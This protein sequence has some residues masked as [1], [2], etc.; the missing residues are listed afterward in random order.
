[1]GS[2]MCIRDRVQWQS[3]EGGARLLVKD[4]GPG[5]DASHINHITARFY[6][7]DNENSRESSGTGLGLSIV[8]HIVQRHRGVLDIRSNPGEGTSFDIRFPAEVVTRDVQGD[9]ASSE[10]AP[11]ELA[12]SDIAPSE[13]T[14]TDLASSGSAPTD[15]D[16]VVRRLPGLG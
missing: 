14:P 5:I 4:N 16:R 1:M 7:V 13:I 6:R 10:L 3:F 12:P 2:E 11:S 8:K 9:I 15:T